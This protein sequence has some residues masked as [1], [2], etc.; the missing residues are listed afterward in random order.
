MA[1]VVTSCLILASIVTGSVLMQK[2]IGS[3]E[4]DTDI[5]R[6]TTSRHGDIYVGTMNK[7]YHLN[8][9][10]IQISSTVM[11]TATERENFLNVLFLVENFTT[12]IGLMTCGILSGCQ[13]RNLANISIHSNITVSKGEDM[14]RLATPLL[15]S[16]D[17]CI[18]MGSTYDLFKVILTKGFSYAKLNEEKTKLISCGISNPMN[19]FDERE[20]INNVAH[21]V[22]GFSI[23]KL[24]YYFMNQ[25]KYGPTVS[26]FCQKDPYAYSEMPIHCAGEEYKVLKAMQYTRINQTDGLLVGVF[27]TSNES[28]SAVCL[29]K[30]SDFQNVMVENIK[31][32]FNGT[33]H[34]KP[35]FKSNTTC[36]KQNSD[37]L[38]NPIDY[39][40]TD[41]EHYKKVVGNLT[42]VGEVIS[43]GGNN[44]FKP[45]AAV[46]VI[47]ISRRTLVLLGSLDGH[48]DEIIQNTDGTWSISN[49]FDLGTSSTTGRDILFDGGRR[50]FYV[51]SKS[52]VF[53]F[54]LQ[55]CDEYKYCHLCLAHVKHTICG[56]CVLQNKCGI[57]E[58]CESTIWLQGPAERECPVVTKITPP[59]LHINSTQ[60][61]VK[62]QLNHQVP[63]D[64][65]YS[66]SLSYSDLRFPATV[67]ED[68]VSCDLSPNW[69]FTSLSVDGL[70]LV[71]VSIF[72][73]WS[74]DAMV[75]DMLTVYDCSHV[76]R[77]TQC[78]RTDFSCSWCFTRNKCINEYEMCSD[79]D[80]VV[81]HAD[82]CPKINVDK[83][84]VISVPNRIPDVFRYIHGQNFPNGTYTC[85]LNL[86]NEHGVGERLN[87][88]MVRCKF[89]VNTTEVDAS[90]D[91]CVSFWLLLE[92]NISIEINNTSK[93]EVHIYQ[94]ENLAGDDCSLCKS[95]TTVDKPM[96]ECRWCGNKCQYGNN[97][98]C[99]ANECP[100]PSIAKVTPLTTHF[101]ASAVITIEG[102]YLG[103]KFDEVNNSVTVG[104]KRCSPIEKEY[105]PSRRIVCRLEPFGYQARVNVTVRLPGKENVNF[106]EQYSFQK[107]F[108][109]KISPSIG[110]KSGGSL[111]RITGE[112]LDTG[113]NVSV[114]IGDMIC[115][116]IRLENSSSVTCV[117]EANK[118]NILRPKQVSM[119]FNGAFEI[120]ENVTFEYKDDPTIWNIYP[121]KSFNSGGRKI[122][123][124][125]ADL[126][127]IQQ[128]KIYVVYKNGMETPKRI[129]ENI[130][131]TAIV[132]PSPGNI[133]KS[134]GDPKP[135]VAFIMDNV[136]SVKNV[137]HH[138]PNV[139]SE[140]TYLDDPSI[141]EFETALVYKE[142]L[143]I[144][145]SNLMDATDKGDI[146]VS[147]G[148]GSCN[149]TA[150][151]SDEILCRPPSDKPEGATC[152]NSTE[153]QQKSM[154]AVKI[155]V[156][157]GDFS[158]SPGCLRYHI[159]SE[160]KSYLIIIV[161]AGAAVFLAVVLSAVLGCIVTKRK[162]T[163]QK[164]DFMLQMDI[165]EG[166][167]R[168]QCRE[169]FAELQTAMTDLKNEL[170]G[171]NVLVR[172]YDNFTYNV[173]FPG[174]KD[175]P[176][177]QQTIL[178]LK[179]C[180]RGLEIFKNLL[181]NKHFLLTFIKTLEAEGAD[182][183]V[184]SEIASLLMV[185]NQDNMQYITDVMKT[186]LEE[187]ID[188]AVASR[189]EKILLRRSE[190][191]VEKL[192]THWLSLC[193]YD[194]LKHSTGS[195]LFYLYKAIKFQVEK[196]PVDYITGC[197]KYTLSEEKIFTGRNQ[198]TQPRS[199]NITVKH[200]M[201][202][203]A[204]EK[205]LTCTVLDCDTISQAKMKMLD[206]FYKNI[207]YSQRPSVHTTVL[208]QVDGENC[209]PLLDEDDTNVKDGLWKC[210]NT[211]RHY[212]ILSGAVMRLSFS[213]QIRSSNIALEDVEPELIFTATIKRQKTILRTISGSHFWHLT[214]QHIETEGMKLSS[215][216]FL[217]TLLN[218]KGTL[219]VYIDDFFQKMLT[220]DDQVPM[221]IK[222][223]FDFFESCAQKHGITDPDVLHTWK[224]NS[225][226]LRFW[227][228]IIKNP[229][230]VFDIYKSSILNSCLSVIAQ[231]LM[232]SCS[233]AELVLGK[234]SPSNKLL[235]AKDIPRYKHMVRA[236][237]Q[238]V[239]QK[240]SVSDQDM[241]SFLND[242]SKNVSDKLYP[243]SAFLE[244]YK[245]AYS[246]KQPLIA[247]F[248]ETEESS[249]S[250][251]TH[252]LLKR[253]HQVY[254]GVGPQL[255]A[256]G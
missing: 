222:Y 186:L 70:I 161:G 87:S 104:G 148:N 248:E 145:G 117:T 233:T 64:S 4:I 55:N 210:L 47:H 152:D 68:T 66:C 121:L 91:T 202:T 192:L 34:F 11:D 88:T 168:N 48:V 187:L 250:V 44:S 181:R 170:E 53:Q 115:T 80:K 136:H 111:V 155:I 30:Y 154:Y 60:T 2:L 129:C 84:G 149:V 171:G 54:Q 89:N 218:T 242:L 31:E 194:Y 107:P 185:V 76:T 23:G 92:P 90:G 7:I 234:H 100:P 208:E 105:L 214:K 153:D 223:L 206:T 72:S 139:S 62:V 227:V 37:T 21:F 225:L 17:G 207:P 32:C 239:N 244:L 83:T 110:P 255:P 79:G 211:L 165:I 65:N 13:M 219:Q 24:D 229:E 109:A 71:N 112:L 191:V 159:D 39:L 123:I 122:I 140:I 137:T 57:L 132:C 40:C 224:C 29:F 97:T 124:T 113:N 134:P 73:N 46:G 133:H 144:K 127:I 245:H 41:L 201:R 1:R 75:S 253:L 177:L 183:K 141:Q 128:P 8:S 135:R 118:G 98:S 167:V 130:N 240:P 33:N 246:I 157:I 95:Y 174:R 9:E 14:S 228:N 221:A 120:G 238:S 180:H 195:A 243:T 63:N 22:Y 69:N 96:Y 256:R 142:I 19:F 158:F 15:F 52:K 166:E 176:V 143:V 215:D 150:L 85:K 162:T 254:D 59:A 78:T 58:D 119:N 20:L 241:N 6:M 249:C 252:E 51:F 138:F 172:D 188:H 82:E 10:L 203:D 36:R 108:I 151:N 184:K 101:N 197:A 42:A 160:E 103:V 67:G 93:M 43:Y 220:A 216:L 235:F 26:K 25:K 18:R 169:A 198:D 173:L 247:A 196:G 217:P 147:V 35:Y 50:H 86:S 5:S 190:C 102:K 114:I 45:L 125:G 77:C 189:N 200:R 179:S 204:E 231:T 27:T 226:L 74:G 81:K 212:K 106:R 251:P 193:L 209:L 236:Y 99:I 38:L 116:D 28:R 163:K 126:Y 182:I 3:V 213:S 237:F 49:S 16:P 56:W 199:L 156:K 230:F 232:D 146:T 131:S 164:K 94:C 61:H 178:E 205:A 175:H 12:D